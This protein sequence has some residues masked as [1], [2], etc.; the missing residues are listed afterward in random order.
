MMKWIARL[1][2]AV[3]TLLVLARAAAAYEYPAP[4]PPQ[5]G[6]PPAYNCCNSGPPPGPVPTPPPAYGCCGGYVA[7]SQGPSAYVPAYGVGQVQPSP[8]L[9]SPCCASAPGGYGD[10]YGS[11]PA[12]GT[13]RI[14]VED[15]YG[16]WHEATGEEYARVYAYAR[17]QGQ[18]QSGAQYLSVPGP[19]C[20]QPPAPPPPSYAPPPYAPAISRRISL[21][22]N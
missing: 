5:T 18:P 10:G 3:L 13:P 1:S 9:G 6:Y 16:Q 7:P 21:P 17:T 8:G 12:G 2:T 20:Q 11:A 14:Y 4:T 19:C 22:R 15:M